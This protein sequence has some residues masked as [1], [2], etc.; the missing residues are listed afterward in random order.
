MILELPPV[1]TSCLM[2]AMSAKPRISCIISTYQDADLIEKKISEIQQQTIFDQ[3]EFIFVE[4]GSPARERELIQPYTEQFSNVRLVTTDDRR[5]LYEAWNLGWEA[6]QADIVCYSN[7]DDALHP[8]CLQQ[9]V[10][11][12]EADAGIEL[13]T[14]MIG[15]QHEESPGEMDSFDVD[16]LKK[17][18]IGRR[19]GPFS[20][21]RKNLSEKMGMFDGKYRIIGDL[22]FWSRAAAAN[23]RAV[24]IKKVLYL[25]TI[26]P[27][28]L[29]KRMDKSPERKY[30]ADKGVKLQWHPALERTTLLHRKIYRM[31]PSPYLVK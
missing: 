9:V 17:L 3:A 30:A 5:T 24:L 27:S 13:C 14:V 29:S 2:T 28:Q 21:W 7:M 8:Q 15:Y 22:D 10:E 1:V 31:F 11:T 25:Y 23:T 6:A 20:A 19:A 4:T 12:M 16:R 26:A 18:K